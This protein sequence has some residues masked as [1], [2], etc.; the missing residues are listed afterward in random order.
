MAARIE[1]VWT[2][3][4]IAAAG[5]EGE[6]EL[7][8]QR[9]RPSHFERLVAESCAQRVEFL[10]VG[11]HALAAHGHVRA[12]ETLDVSIRAEPENAR[13]AFA[14]L[15]ASGAPFDAAWRERIAVSL[16]SPPVPVVSKRH[17]LANMKATGRLQD[18]ADVE[19]LEADESERAASSRPAP[20][21]SRRAP[22]SARPSRPS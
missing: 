15:A 17:S 7:R 10:V 12:A 9:P 20:P 18:L 22:H 13:R 3:T 5:T 1:A 2:L 14:A 6:L 21:P 8:L 4:K 11:A 16:G 19:R